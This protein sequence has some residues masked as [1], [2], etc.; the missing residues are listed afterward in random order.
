MN[1]WDIDFGLSLTKDEAYFDV[2]PSVCIF[3]KPEHYDTESGEAVGK[4][5]GVN[6]CWLILGITIYR[7]EG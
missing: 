3:K 5:F 6:I 1:G 2:L 7:K 4:V